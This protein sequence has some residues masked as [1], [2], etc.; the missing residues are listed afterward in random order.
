LKKQQV[1]AVVHYAERHL[2]TSFFRFGFRGGDHRLDRRKIQNF[3]CWQIHVWSGSRKIKNDCKN[4]GKHGGDA[5][6]SDPQLAL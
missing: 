5:S 4:E 2:H 3:L 1:S 6:K